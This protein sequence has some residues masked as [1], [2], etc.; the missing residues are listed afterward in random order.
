MIFIFS[1]LS[2]GCLFLGLVGQG[3]RGDR[4]RAGRELGKGEFDSACE[5]VAEE[6][7]AIVG[8]AVA[9]VVF[10]AV[11]DASGF[12]TSSVPVKLNQL[13]AT[14]FFCGVKA[15][16][17]SNC[18]SFFVELLDCVFDF[19]FLVWFFVFVSGVVPSICGHSRT[20]LKSRQQLF[21]KK[22]KKVFW[23]CGAA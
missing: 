9:V 20:L 8:H 15:V 22:V 11:S 18:E 3:W 14:A 19:H 21:F 17:F 4:T 12:V 23:A 6:S 16:G 7:C 10:A 2:F 5:A 1:V 13:F